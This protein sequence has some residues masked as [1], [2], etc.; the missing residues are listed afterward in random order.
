[1]SKT[2]AMTLEVVTRSTVTIDVE[3]PDGV[4]PSRYGYIGKALFDATP[5]AM[6]AS[7]ERH[8]ERVSFDKSDSQSFLTVRLNGDDKIELVKKDDLFEL[9]LLEGVDL[10]NPSELNI[11]N[12]VI[13][14]SGTDA[15]GRAIITSPA[16][17]EELTIVTVKISHDTPE[18]RELAIKIVDR[19][20]FKT[21]RPESVAIQFE[22]FSDEEL[23]F[24]NGSSYMEVTAK[25]RRP[26]FAFT[27]SSYDEFERFFCGM[28][29]DG[30]DLTA[31]DLEHAFNVYLKDRSFTIVN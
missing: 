15:Q 3:V 5:A 19:S 4:G 11:G 1:M 14:C 2:I 23:N 17:P 29:G 7:S 6:F 12:A 25:I 13:L 10:D 21:G 24:L 22:E 26:R 20:L 28:Y 8:L 31:V 16:T 27:L 18:G 9:S 30:E